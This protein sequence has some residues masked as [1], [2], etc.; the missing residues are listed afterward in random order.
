MIRTDIFRRGVPWMLLIK[1]SGTSETDLNVKSA[2]KA[3]VALTG[4][5]LLAG[6][7]SAFFPSAPAVVCRR[8]SRRSCCLNIE[9]FRFL[10][11]RKGLLFAAAAV[12]LHLD[13]LLLLRA[14]GCDRRIALAAPGPDQT[15]RLDQP[16]ERAPIPAPRQSLRPGAL[17]G[18]AAFHAGERAPLKLLRPRQT[19]SADD[20][21]RSTERLAMRIGIDGS[22]LSNRRG[23]GRFSRPSARG[24]FP[25]TDRARLHRLRRSA[26]VTG[27]IDPRSFRASDRRRA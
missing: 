7:A 19:S 20:R 23:F 25:S 16:P 27:D 3:C 24:P 13:L 5:A 10:A 6:A 17:A 9:F 2:Q 12:P 18:P 22:C 4:L 15:T 1:R 26:V 11:R 8:R 14:L 21:S